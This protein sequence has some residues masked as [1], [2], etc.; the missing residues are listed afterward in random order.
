MKATNFSSNIARLEDFTKGWY[1]GNF[2]PALLKTEDVEVG[3]KY[4]R[5]GDNEVS[6][7]HKI[8]TEI[9]AIISGRV[10]M[11]DREF[12]A[13][14]VVKMPPGT[15]TAFEV[16]ED[17]VTVVVKHPGASDDKYLD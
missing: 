1:V 4:Y 12:G 8:A 13:G 5:K 9:T 14:D 6:H 2:E 3:I 10:W 15:S 16:L 17:A 7:H 11:L